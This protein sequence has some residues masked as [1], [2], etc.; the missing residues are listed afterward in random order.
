[1]LLTPM[2]LG[3]ITKEFLGLKRFILQFSFCICHTH[4]AVLLDL[5]TYVVSPAQGERLV[6][7]SLLKWWAAPVWSYSFDRAKIPEM[8]RLCFEV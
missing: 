4:T 6:S 2:T 3:L 1:M 7:Q 5:K 8:C